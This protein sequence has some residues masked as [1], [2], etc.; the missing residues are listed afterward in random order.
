MAS[1]GAG[2]ENPEAAGRAAPRARL[3]G[4]ADRLLVVKPPRR[5]YLPR[6]RVQKVFRTVHKLFCFSPTR[7]VFS[8]LFASTRASSAR[9]IQI[10]GGFAK[11]MFRQAATQVRRDQA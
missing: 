3:R 6:G 1:W 8:V 10:L 11:E 7:P 9:R 5:I 4:H 2:R